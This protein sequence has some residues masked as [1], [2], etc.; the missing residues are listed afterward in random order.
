MPSMGYNSP[1]SDLSLVPFCCP[2]G[3]PGAGRT[4]L[5]FVSR[6]PLSFTVSSTDPI[7]SAIASAFLGSSFVLL[8]E[9]F[10]FRKTTNSCCG[11]TV[12]GVP[13]WLRVVS[14][15]LLVS[16]AHV[17]SA[18]GHP[19]SDAE[20]G[21]TPENSSTQITPSSDSALFRFASLI[22]SDTIQVAS[23][24]ILLY[25]LVR[26]R[27]ARRSLAIA[28]VAVASLSLAA[29]VVGSLAGFKL[30]V[31]GDRGIASRVE[32]TVSISLFLL[33]D[34]VLVVGLFT[35]TAWMQAPIIALTALAI[36]HA[37]AISFWV[38]QSND[39]ANLDEQYPLLSQTVPLPTLYL[40]SVLLALQK[41]ALG[42]FLRGDLCIHAPRSEVSESQTSIFAAP[43]KATA[44][45]TL[46]DEEEGFTVKKDPIHHI[47]A[48]RWSRDSN[49]RRT[50]SKLKTKATITK[51]R[52][53]GARQLLN[54]TPKPLSPVSKLQFARPP[55]PQ[56][57]P[58][59]PS[60]LSQDPY[61]SAYIPGG[62]AFPAPHLLQEP[63]RSAPFLPPNVMVRSN[64]FAASNLQVLPKSSTRH[65]QDG[66]L[67]SAASPS[68]QPASF[69]P[70]EIQ[71]RHSTS[72]E[73]T[74]K[75]PRA[76]KMSIQ[77]LTSAETLG[78]AMLSVSDSDS[79]TT[80]SPHA[81]SSTMVQPTQPVVVRHG[82]TE[83]TSTTDSG[84]KFSGTNGR[85][86]NPYSPL[87]GLGDESTFFNRLRG[88]G[89]FEGTR[90]RFSLRADGATEGGAR[91]MMGLEGWFSVAW[92]MSMNRTKVGD[93]A[94]PLVHV[95][96]CGY[97]CCKP[98]R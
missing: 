66:Q 42:Y 35:S 43:L 10:K 74:I 53:R 24:C 50:K 6:M 32:G 68:H 38:T 55:P 18:D 31:D 7:A 90:T 63:T 94:L 29:G 57:V 37:G 13:A 4:P 2:A 41:T 59:S 76:R 45:G 88:A 52:R 8:V 86:F 11:C 77:I 60:A 19:D 48:S 22:V 46:K 78:Q 21:S 67:P 92:C 98:S 20:L 87:P 25:A 64:T 30:W 15:Q 61:A 33:I 91:L 58:K 85:L 1:F 47:Q 26:S 95:L 71:S 79:T 5:S 54:Q 44:G 84:Y 62:I 81:Q 93:A 56:D 34:V 23:Q 75:G 72:S 12:H 28:A 89:G 83:S 39:N 14:F 80:S 9:F 97:H 49:A 96:R 3:S 70:Q 65:F 69:V 82:L 36:L 16:S 27:G 51:S 40:I 73:R 17:K